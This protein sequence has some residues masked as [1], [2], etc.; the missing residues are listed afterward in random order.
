MKNHNKTHFSTLIRTY[1]NFLAIY[2][3]S[4]KITDEN[5]NK[6]RHINECLMGKKEFLKEQY[7]SIF[8][9]IYVFLETPE[10][11]SKLNNWQ[12]F[13][14]MSKKKHCNIC[15]MELVVKDK[16]WLKIPV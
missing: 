1:K 9:E 3:Q 15:R 10:I 13:R 5:F 8:D 2:N 12:W 4:G 16:L 7:G 14:V 6:I 11:K